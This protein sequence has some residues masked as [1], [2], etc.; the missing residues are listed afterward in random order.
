MRHDNSLSTG[1][2]RFK[3]VGRALNTKAAVGS[4]GCLLRAC[5]EEVSSHFSHFNVVMTAGGRVRAP[6]VKPIKRLIWSFS[7]VFISFSPSA[8]THLLC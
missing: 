8:D 3:Y 5:V 6:T 4:T 2:N 1:L 7:F